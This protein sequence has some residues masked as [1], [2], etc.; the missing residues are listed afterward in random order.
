MPCNESLDCDLLI[1]ISIRNGIKTMKVVKGV[2]GDYNQEFPL[3]P[4][5]TGENTI[6]VKSL[7]TLF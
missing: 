6:K 2:E 7:R 4:R 1:S 5:S 3:Y